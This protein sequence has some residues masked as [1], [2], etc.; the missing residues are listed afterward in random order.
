MKSDDKQY[1]HQLDNLISLYAEACE[2]LN[3]LGIAYSKNRYGVYKQ[4]FEKFTE[5]ENNYSKLENED[6][7]S[8]KKKFDN[9]YLEVNQ[10]IRIYDRLKEIDSGEFME[11]IRKVASGQEFRANSE[12][13]QAR[14]FLFEL[15][16]ASRFMKAGFSI[17]LT[18]ICDVV[19]D[20]VGDGKLFVEC[21]RIKSQTKIGANIKKASK[22]IHSRVK[23]DASSKVYGL[24]AINVSDLLPSSSALRPNSMK[25]GTAI[26]RAISN[27]FI[28]ANLE[29]ITSER[30][31][32]S[33]GVMCV[34][35]VMTH[36]LVDAKT[37]GLFYSRHTEFIPYCKSSILE[38]LAPR[39]SNQDII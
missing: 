31:G 34:S 27:N 39:I 19:V 11:Q 21:K 28:R 6:L 20:L 25:E 5:L 36:L 23:A 16:I 33:L 24:I 12:N 15:S 18:G 17:S 32:K 3:E 38:E 7:L 22:Q 9:A 1:S 29:Q 4:H 8:F 2:W 10:L 14:D 30:R 26:H 13:D 37:P 35:E